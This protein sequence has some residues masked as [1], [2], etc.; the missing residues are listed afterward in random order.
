MTRDEALAQFAAMQERTLKQLKT[1][2]AAKSWSPSEKLYTLAMLAKDMMA[3][4]IAIEMLKG[5]GMPVE[6][7]AEIDAEARRGSSR[8][9]A[10]FN[11][12]VARIE[13]KNAAKICGND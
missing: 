8:R 12:K 7:A 1:V 3:I 2:R 5:H 13:P 10:K 6:S 11:R 4:D 9:V